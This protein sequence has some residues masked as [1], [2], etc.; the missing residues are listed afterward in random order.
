MASATTR[1]ELEQGLAELGLPLSPEQVDRLLAYQELLAKWN[2]RVNLISGGELDEFVSRHLL[3]SLAIAHALE[4][5][6]N[7]L[8]VGSGGGL[9]G[10]PL[11]IALP[12]QQFTLLDS[13]GKKTRFL[14]QAALSLGLG[15]VEVANCRVEHYQSPRQIDIVT[16][17]AFSSLAEILSRTRHCFHPE[18]ELLAMKGRYPDEEIAG[19]PNG[20]RVAWTRQLTIPGIDSA[21]HLIAVRMQDT[22]SG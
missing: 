1:G 10:I 15:N 16:C 17:R 9:P 7:I 19:L 18:T 13:N 12:D 22:D 5:A 11:A 3:D 8:D 6:H 14:F 2:R 4:S 20:Y 21:R